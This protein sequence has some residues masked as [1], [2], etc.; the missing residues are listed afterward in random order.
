MNSELSLGFLDTCVVH[1]ANYDKWSRNIDTKK[2]EQK[3]KAGVRDIE[4]CM[5]DLTWK[6]KQ[7]DRGA[8]EVE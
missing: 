4:R 2:M 1:T 3:L 6:E 7:M 5:L 8:S